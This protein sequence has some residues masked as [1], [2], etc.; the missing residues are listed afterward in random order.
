MGNRAPFVVLLSFEKI[1]A[2]AEVCNSRCHNLCCVSF[3]DRV[4]LVRMILSP[5]TLQ[6]DVFASLFYPTPGRTPHPIPSAPLLCP[7]VFCSAGG[8]LLVGWF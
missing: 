8:I 5:F 7:F 3:G 6:L 1:F 2:S 4:V